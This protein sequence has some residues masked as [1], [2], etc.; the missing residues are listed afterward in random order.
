MKTN[1]K[2]KLKNAATKVKGV[3]EKGVEGFK[4]AWGTKLGKVVIVGSLALSVAG[5]GLGIGFGVTSRDKGEPTVVIVQEEKTPEQIAKEEKIL[6]ENN[7]KTEILTGIEEILNNQ[8]NPENPE[9]NIMEGAK[10]FSISFNKAKGM[11]S[12]DMAITVLVPEGEKSY[13]IVYS[14]V[15]KQN[16]EEIPM[17]ELAGLVLDF[18]TIG[19][20]QMVIFE[21][22]REFKS[23]FKATSPAIKYLNGEELSEEE[24]KAGVKVVEKI[25]TPVQTAS[26]APQTEIS[27]EQ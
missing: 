10:V 16:L 4:H 27:P 23:G 2:E 12:Y 22:A 7:N 1:I 14:A 20:E 9:E 3:A 18:V 17:D 26:N 6:K 13:T 8:F 5:A 21:D 19:Q 15:T 11:P 25:T 24:Q